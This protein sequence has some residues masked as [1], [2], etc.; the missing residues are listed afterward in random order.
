MADE[1]TTVTVPEITVQELRDRLEAGEPVTILDIRSRD[2]FEEWRIPGSLHAE[3]LDESADLPAGGE[4]PFVTV[5]PSGNKSRAAA[6][7]LRDGGREAFSLKGGLRAWSLAW[8]VAELEAGD[9]PARVVQVRRTGKGCLSYLV[10]S[11]D[12]AL[13]LDPAVAPEVFEAEAA[14]RGWRIVGVLETHVHADHLSRARRLAERTGARLYLPRAESGSGSAAVSF[15]HHALRE[16]DAVGVGDVELDVLATPGHTPESVSYRLGDEA[17]FTG[18]TLFLDGVGRPDLDADAAEGRR[19]ARRL[20]GSL[21]RLT[22]L[23]D[24][25]TVLPAHTAS[26]VAF[27]GVV[28]GA[29]LGRVRERVPALS[30]PAD[31]FVRDVLERIPPTPANHEEIIALN[32]R[33]ARPDDRDVVDLEAGANRC[34]AG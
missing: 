9:L 24:R 1:T 15:P 2:A 17:V 22:S 29:P 31:A 8:N 7:R 20:H 34:A 16:G 18:D 4:G 6:K 13:V 5:C 28:V 14:E 19:K 26:P 12:E 11:R 10:G 27:D 23:P 30:K 21:R 32:R 33:G 3:G 25:I